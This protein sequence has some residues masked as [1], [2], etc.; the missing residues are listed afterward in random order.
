LFL[1]LVNHFDG[2]KNPEMVNSRDIVIVKAPEALAEKGASLFSETALA[3]V[4]ERDRFAVAL[5]GG[6]TPRRMHV[7]LGQGP[8]RSS[9]PWSKVHLYWG[10]ERCVPETSR[11]SNYGRA[12]EDFLDR[13]DIPGENIHPMPDHLPPEEGA[14]LYEKE[15]TGGF[16]LVF[17]GLG[18]DGHT[19]SLFPGHGTLG[20]RKRWVVPVKGG[21][22][23]ISR[24]TVTLS[25]INMARKV[26]FLVSG[27][28]KAGAVKSVLVDH[29]TRLPATHVLPLSGSLTWILDRDA[30][31]LLPKEM[32]CEQQ[33]Q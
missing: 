21:D 15:I 33:P 19:A 12:K 8:Y 25:L 26:V 2:E 1:I 30:A 14:S 18:R 22:P 4:A 32:I 11:W 10:D 17:L 13:L 9:I 16:D 27:E 28:N 24:L 7:M 29:D 23:D 3:C 31:S 6:S 20:E 5:S